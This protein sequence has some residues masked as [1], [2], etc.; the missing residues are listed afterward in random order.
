MAVLMNDKRMVGWLL[1]SLLLLGGCSASKHPM[2]QMVRTQGDPGIAVDR[3]ATHTESR[4]AETKLPRV[5]IIGDSISLG[6][7]PHVTKT[8]KSGAVIKHHKGNAEH[9]GTG[10]KKLDQWIGNT[11]WDVIHF[12]WGLWDLCYRHPESKVQGHRDK[13][14]G[15][16]TT[17]LVQY[18][19][20]LEA[21][22]IRLKMTNANLIW[23]HTTVVPENEAGRFVGDDKRYNDVAVRIMKK[24]KV[25]INDLNSLTRCFPSEYF[26]QPGN[27]HYT[28]RGYQ[29]IARQVADKI[30]T[31]LKGEQEDS[32][33]KN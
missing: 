7:T 3:M 4:E 9:T 14:N 32:D 30:L 13:V 6:Y 15:T 22:V 29:K 5:L 23:A 1:C 17:T 19:K 2:A 31:S 33:A 24:H 20:N 10:L 27:V 16:V 8:L 11:Q 12:N 28:K 26:T 18:E 21:L 25:P